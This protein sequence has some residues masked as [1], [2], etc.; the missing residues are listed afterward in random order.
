[1]LSDP[2]TL[3]K[4]MTLYLLQQ[5]SV[6]LTEDNLSDFFLSHKYTSFYTLKQALS[7]LQD[8]DLIRMEQVRGSSRYSITPEG[9]ETFRFFGKK[10]SFEIISDMDAW[11]KENRFRIR[12]EASVTADYYKTSDLNYMVRCAILEGKTPLV[13]ISLNA[14]DEEQAELICR[15]W[16]AKSQPVYAFILQSLLGNREG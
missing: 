12:S 1:M 15:N 3:Y 2:M 14:A 16:E 11:L 13:S 4:L 7:E 10:V 8:A 6:P 5:V 9:E